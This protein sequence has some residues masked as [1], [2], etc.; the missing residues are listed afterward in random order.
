MTSPA[1]RPVPSVPERRFLSGAVSFDSGTVRARWEIPPIHHWVLRGHFPNNP[2]TPGAVILDACEQAALAAS[3]AGA[4]DAAFGFKSLT[5]VRFRRQTLPGDILDIFLH[6]TSRSAGSGEV[7]CEEDTVCTFR[8]ELAGSEPT[9]DESVAAEVAAFAVGGTGSVAGRPGPDVLHQLPPFRFV[10][11]VLDYSTASGA[12]PIK[13]ITDWTA[14]T[15]HQMFAGLGDAP[16]VSGP[17]LCEVMGQGMSTAIYTA[18]ECKDRTLIFAVLRSAE[19]GRP[20]RAG[21]TVVTYGN[22]ESIGELGGLGRCIATVNGEPV[23]AMTVSGA[24]IGK[25]GD[26]H[27]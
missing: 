25:E 18:P 2:I 21:E 19:F 4:V 10:D 13:V 5:K 14:P 27:E 7:R 15:S 12:A 24:F 17:L 6:T 8:F 9:L 23:A 22:C 11:R 3:E 1:A 20:V 16:F 26:D